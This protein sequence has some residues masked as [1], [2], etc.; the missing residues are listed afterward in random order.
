M[1]YPSLSTTP[2]GARTRSCCCWKPFP[3]T[4]LARGAPSPTTW[5]PRTRPAARRTGR[6]C[7]R[8]RPAFRSR[9]LCPRWQ[10]SRAAEAAALPTARRGAARRQPRPPPERRPPLRLVLVMAL[11]PRPRE[12]ATAGA[13]AR[14]APRAARR[15]R[16]WCRAA[17]PLPRPRVVAAPEACPGVLAAPTRPRWRHQGVW[18]VALPLRGL[19]QPVSTHAAMSTTPNSTT[20]PNC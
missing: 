13:W 11:P 7:M 6:R 20:T 2:P 3:R 18:V 9:V 15:P 12:T 14:T 5:A 1:I 8:R 16:P 4:A 10:V 19:I 17:L